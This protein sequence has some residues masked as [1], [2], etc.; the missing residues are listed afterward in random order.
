MTDRAELEKLSN[1]EL[2]DR[3]TALAKHRLD[4]AF[5]WDLLKTIPEAEAASGNLERSETD[6]V[7]PLALLNDFFDADEGRLAE[8]LR[9]FYLDYLEENEGK[10]DG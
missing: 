3:A 5:L 1:K 9:P 7:R 8:A 6:I 10:P 4:A 2:H